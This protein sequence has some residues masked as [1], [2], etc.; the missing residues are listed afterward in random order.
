MVSYSL[1]GFKFSP[2]PENVFFESVS[3]NSL[4]SSPPFIHLLMGSSF[5]FEVENEFIF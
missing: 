2:P 5:D 4:E 3:L 1:Y